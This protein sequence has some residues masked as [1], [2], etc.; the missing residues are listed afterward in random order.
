MDKII[1]TLD[2]QNNGY[3]GGDGFGYGVGY[4]SINGGD[5]RFTLGYEKNY[6]TGDGF[7]FGRNKNYD[8]N[9]GTGCGDSY[10]DVFGGGYDK[11]RIKSR[12][13][14]GQNDY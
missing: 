4:P 1:V 3:G 5:S 6:G 7:G 8:E 9:S 12:V 2:G 14:T 11:H 10:G 13:D